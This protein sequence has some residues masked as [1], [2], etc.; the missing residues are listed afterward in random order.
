M[1]RRSETIHSYIYFIYVG[2]TWINIRIE[3]WPRVENL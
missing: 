2:L 1:S 3:R